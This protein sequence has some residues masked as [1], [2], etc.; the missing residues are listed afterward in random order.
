MFYAVCTSCVFLR[1]FARDAAVEAV[2][3]SCPMC[4]GEL[5]VRRSGERFQP[6]YIGRVSLDLHATPALFSPRQRSR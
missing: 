3:E 2:P 1:A 4:G 5:M 6:T